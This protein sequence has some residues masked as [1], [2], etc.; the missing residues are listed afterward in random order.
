MKTANDRRIETEKKIRNKVIRALLA[1]G[2]TVSVYDGEAWALKRS[3]NFKEIVEATWSTDTD[4][5]RARDKDGNHL[6]DVTLIYGNDIDLI[7]DWSEKLDAVI[8]PVLD[9]VDEQPIRLR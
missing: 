5:L 1:G 3:A 8:Q 6:G 4:V 7:H 9:W 2:N